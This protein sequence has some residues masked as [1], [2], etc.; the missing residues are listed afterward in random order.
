M[1]A[2]RIGLF[3]LRFVFVE[4]RIVQPVFHVIVLELAFAGLVADRAIQRMIGKQEFQN[5]TPVAQGLP[6]FG[7]GRSSPRQTGVAQEGC[8]L[9]V[10]SISTRHMRQLPT[11]ES[12]G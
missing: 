1:R 9:G 6:A 11:T 2:D 4:A 7:C 5:G 10:F 12:P 8:S 3:P